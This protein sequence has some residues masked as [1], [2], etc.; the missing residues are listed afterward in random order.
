MQSSSRTWQTCGRNSKEN[1]DHDKTLIRVQ[2]KQT[3]SC[4]EI[5]VGLIIH[6]RT[7]YKRLERLNWYWHMKIY[8]PTINEVNEV[9]IIVLNKTCLL[10][11]LRFPQW[12]TYIPCLARLPLSP[13]HWTQKIFNTSIPGLKRLTV[14]RIE[15]CPIKISGWG[16]IN[17]RRHGQLPLLLCLQL[18]AG[19]LKAKNCSSKK[20]LLKI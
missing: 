13:R 18:I 2:Q 10:V 11:D 14:K 6:W 4:T 5:F 12:L 16:T 3:F 20:A 19:H 7:H 9:E 1:N 8:W 17:V 15:T